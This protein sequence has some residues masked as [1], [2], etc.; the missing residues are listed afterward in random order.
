[1]IL[2]LYD[3]K[4]GK[5]VCFPELAVEHVESYAMLVHGTVENMGSIHLFKTGEN[6]ASVFLSSKPCKSLPVL[7]SGSLVSDCPSRGGS[8]GSILFENRNGVPIVR[9]MT[10]GSPVADVKVDIY[11]PGT[12]FTDGPS[13]GYINHYMKEG[14]DY[15]YELKNE[16][17]ISRHTIDQ[18]FAKIF[19]SYED[20]LWAQCAGASTRDDC[21]RYL[22]VWPNGKHAAG[23]RIKIADLERR[24]PSQAGRAQAGSR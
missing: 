7:H 17:A 14:I 11:E 18:F 12:Y 5:P 10:A 15:E 20:D 21:D 24:S 19:K 6:S 9:A 16:F 23:A 22:N 1:M 3:P 8:S 13:F 4:T 2:K